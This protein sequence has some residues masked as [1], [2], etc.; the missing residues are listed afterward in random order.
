M[1]EFIEFRLSYK[2]RE[3][4]AMKFEKPEMIVLEYEEK[5]RNNGPERPDDRGASGWG[6]C[7]YR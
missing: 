2:N 6:N 4:S 7:C 1:Y 3:V 5:E